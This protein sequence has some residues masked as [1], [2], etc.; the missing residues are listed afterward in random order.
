MNIEEILTKLVEIPSI[1]SDT[2]SCKKIIDYIDTLVK[3]RWLKY[4]DI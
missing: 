2:K 3:K 4:K 1:T